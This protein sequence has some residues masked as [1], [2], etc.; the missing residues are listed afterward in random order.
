MAIG[1]I[2]KLITFET[3]DKRILSPQGI[4]KEVSGRWATHSRIGKKPL[5]QFLGPDTETV[6]FSIVLDARHG[7]KP[8]QTLT[9]IEKDI[10][11]G[12]PRTIAIGGKK[13]IPNKIT[14]NSIS[15]TYDEVWNRGELVR[16]KAELTIEEYL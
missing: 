8:R 7:V 5:R 10:R 3:S 9:A 2:G 15:E 16:A 6:S 1:S 11:K 12:T 4:K 13:V 14:I